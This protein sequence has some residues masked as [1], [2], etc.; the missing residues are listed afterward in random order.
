MDV[1]EQNLWTI[2]RYPIQDAGQW[3]AFCDFV[4]AV[5][6]GEIV[7]N[8]STPAVSAIRQSPHKLILAIT[9][10]RNSG[11]ELL[12]RVPVRRLT[13][14][15]NHFSSMISTL[16]VYG[17]SRT[18]EAVKGAAYTFWQNIENLPDSSDWS[19]ASE[20]ASTSASSSASSS[21]SAATFTA[22]PTP[23]SVSATPRQITEQVSTPW[24]LGLSAAT[25]AG[26]IWYIKTRETI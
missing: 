25:I 11:Y 17:A 19:T 7:N 23:V 8:P 9:R 4:A 16:K 20:S 5:G 13:A 18:A 15:P 26:V 24:A 2:A 14:P 3:Y 6:A 1:F 22:A 21:S 12:Q 10:L